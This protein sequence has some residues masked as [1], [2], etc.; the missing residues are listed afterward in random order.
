LFL[1]SEENIDHAVKQ[2]TFETAAV[3]EHTW[4]VVSI[5]ESALKR[6]A[7]QRTCK[8]VQR[9]HILSRIDRAIYLFKR[10]EPINEDVLINYFFEH[11]T[12]ALI[13][14][15]ENN[16][17]GTAHWSKLYAVPNGL[18]TAGSYS[19]RARKSD[20]RWID[21]TMTKATKGLRGA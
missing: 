13:M 17:H 20:L 6:I 2:R 11:D 3:S 9:G 7:S 1:F 10:P 19:I 21:E 12:V 18:F 15:E 5:S 4:R 14:K 8:N 16:N